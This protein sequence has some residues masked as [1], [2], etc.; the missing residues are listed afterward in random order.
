MGKVIQMHPYREAKRVEQAF[1]SSTQQ[2]NAY[3]G[4]VI[5][6]ILTTVTKAIIEA[7]VAESNP[8]T[9]S[10]DIAAQVSGDK[11]NL[12]ISLAIDGK[13][14]PYCAVTIWKASNYGGWD[15]G[16]PSA[17]LA[18][19]L[20][21]AQYP[22]ADLFIPVLLLARSLNALGMKKHHVWK[23]SMLGVTHV[24]LSMG[25]MIEDMHLRTGFTF[26]HDAMVRIGTMLTLQ[27]IV[28][29]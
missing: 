17:C 15:D 23:T 3:F 7:G 26:N 13:L 18:A 16:E 20:D 12:N 24:G 27:G 11:A 8:L 4:K 10:M 21:K 29:V 22:V 14:Y 2:P 6:A 9:N 19:A 1:I 25:G 28:R 5:R